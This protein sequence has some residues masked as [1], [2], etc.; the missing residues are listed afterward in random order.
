MRLSSEP[1]E[2]LTDNVR[3]GMGEEVFGP[4][5]MGCNKRGLG[6]REERYGV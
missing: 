1:V 3:R 4:T 2:V 5:G 6:D